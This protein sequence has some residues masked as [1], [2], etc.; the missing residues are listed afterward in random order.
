M[1]GPIFNVAKVIPKTIETST[2]LEIRV[3]SMGSLALMEMEMK[4]KRGSPPKAPV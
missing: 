4:G 1:N 3:W 2:D